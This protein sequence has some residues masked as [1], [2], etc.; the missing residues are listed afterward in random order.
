MKIEDGQVV[1]D[2]PTREIGATKTYSDEYVR[3][4]ARVCHEANR[5]YCQTIG[6]W[7]QRPFNEAPAWQQ[8][9]AENGVR[10][11][12]AVPGGLS[13][14]ASHESWMAEKVAAGWVYGAVKDEN[15]KTHHCLVA[16][17]D[18]PIAQRAKDA[19]FGAIVEALR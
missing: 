8:V 12:L 2:V 14:R 18:L 16:Y 3:D 5:A 6:D 7:S 1:I 4:I 11:H 13:P 19:L 17:D 9:S 10:A 15:L